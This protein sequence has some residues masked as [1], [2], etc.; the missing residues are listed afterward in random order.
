MELSRRRCTGSRPR[1]RAQ[2]L[3]GPVSAGRRYRL[4]A[5]MYSDGHVG[6]I[7]WRRD[8]EPSRQ[9]GRPRRPARVSARGRGDHR[10]DADGQVPLPGCHGVPASPGRCTGTRHGCALRS[11]TA[12]NR[13][14]AAGE[15]PEQTAHRGQRTAHQTDAATQ[16]TY[17]TGQL[18]GVAANGVG[19]HFQT[20]RNARR[21]PT[22]PPTRR[23]C[24]QPRRQ[25]VRQQAE[26]GVA[27]GTVPAGEHAVLLTVTTGAPGA[28]AGRGLACVGAMPRQGCIAPTLSRNVLLAGTRGP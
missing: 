28:S 4:D 15:A 17:R 1:L 3:Q 24:R 26:R 21:R 27:L 2:A 6:A 23:A 22:R 13:R 8:R 16:P 18:D 5:S 7:L 10:Q 19:R 20:S 11:R 9:P 25:A 14:R 12:R